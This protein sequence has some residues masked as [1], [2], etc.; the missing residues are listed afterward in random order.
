MTTDSNRYPGRFGAYTRLLVSNGC[1]RLCRM[2]FRRQYYTEN[3]VLVYSMWQ[4]EIYIQNAPVI[5]CMRRSQISRVTLASR[6]PSSS[7]KSPGVRKTKLTSVV[8]TFLSHW[9]LILV[10]SKSTEHASPRPPSSAKRKKVE[11]DGLI[12][13]ASKK[14]RTRVR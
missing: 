12:A 3:F 9:H 10:M 11:E 4:E 13:L 6:I 14:Q 5:T 7:S 8:I 2:Q 1:A